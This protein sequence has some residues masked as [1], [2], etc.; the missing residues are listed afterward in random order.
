MLS[1]LLMWKCSIASVSA[2]S[3]EPSKSNKIIENF[4]ALKFWNYYIFFNFEQCLQTQHGN[5]KF[6]HS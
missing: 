2:L 4:E 3:P 1:N 5:R 6:I